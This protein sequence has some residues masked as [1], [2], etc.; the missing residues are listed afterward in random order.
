MASLAQSI[1]NSTRPLSLLW[2]FLKEELSPYPGRVATVARMVLAA[3]LVMIICN[4]FRIPYAFQG[5]I[6]VLLITRESPQATLQSARTMCLATGISTAYILIL[7]NFVIS[8]PTLHFLWNIGSFFVV[9]YALSSLTNYGAAVMFAIVV[10][11]AIPLWDRHVSAETN[12]EDTLWLVLASFTGVAVTAAV[13]LA[14]RRTRPGD[15]IVLPIA[16]RLAAVHS[17]L[18]YYAEGR[19]PEEKIENT[20][21]KLE[22]LGTSGLRRAL[23]RSN[24]SSE[25]RI[26]MSGVTVLVGRLVDRAAILTELSVAGV[27]GDPSRLGRLA[28]SVASIRADLLRQRVPGPIQLENDDDAAGVIPLLREMEKIVALIPQ[29]FGGSRQAEECVPF[30]ED[31]QQATF[32]VPD[33]FVNPEHVRFA[34]KGWLAATICYIVYNLI[35]WPGISTSVTT[36]LLTALSTIGASRQKQVLRFGGAI[37]GGFGIGLAA[38]VFVLPY[39]A[40]IIGF[41]VLFML[42]TAFASW[43][44]T[45]SPRL[46]YFGVQVALAFYLINLQEFAFQTSLSIARDRVVGVLFGLFA[47]WMVFDQLWGKSAAVEMKRMFISNLRL[48]AEF[49]R[50]PLSAESEAAIKRSLS[51]RETINNGLDQVRTLTD[52]VLF[53]FGPTRQ[54][55]LALRAR[56]IRWQSQLRMIFVTGIALWNY[57]LQLPGFELPKPVADAQAAFDESLTKVLDGMADR[58]EGAASVVSEDVGRLVDRLNQT[59][60]ACYQG[61][62]QEPLAPKLETYV[63]LS[64]RIES[65]ASS[66]DREISG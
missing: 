56:I 21:A 31:A 3:T 32:L 40:S 5:A 20:V 29:A 24:Y 13:E 34:L 62:S 44:M 12:V 36:C 65:L 61:K 58:M 39:V 57:R 33:A 25:Y 48:M 16:E 54:Q 9:F 38:Q 55:D 37:A 22:V 4:T 59:I 2:R 30:P 8:V 50:G 60:Q 28:A 27:G 6:Y 7:A 43:I 10:S 41:T 26:Q 15:D 18:L 66:L 17:L 11:V 47:M 45:S 19:S 51:F 23:R 63:S 35:D 49:V 14:F 46:S 53:E 64:R 52:G 1:T 42:V